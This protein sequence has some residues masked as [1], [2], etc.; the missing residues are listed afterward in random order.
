M[1]AVKEVPSLAWVTEQLVLCEGLEFADALALAQ[2][3]E[4]RMYERWELLFAPEE[5]VRWLQIVLSG[6]VKITRAT[7]G[8]KEIILEI[9]GPG[10]I[11]GE[12]HFLNSPH[13]SYAEVVEETVTLNVPPKAL[14][15]LIRTRPAVGRLLMGALSAKL[16]ERE[17]QVEDLVL[18]SVPARVAHTLLKLA[19]EHGIM[20]S[21]TQLIDMRLTHQDVANMV[22]ASRETVTNV[23]NDFRSKGWVDLAHRQIALRDVLALEEMADL[24]LSKN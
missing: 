5:E 12:E 9:L 17:E 10:Q 6:R 24:E 7:D 15:N 21:G 18:R 2:A 13:R 19:D 1:V 3:G 16:Q 20:K 22:G 23:L 14:E 8:G 11:I 4:V